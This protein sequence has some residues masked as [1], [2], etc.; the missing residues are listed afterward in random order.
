MNAHNPLWKSPSLNR[1][2]EIIESILDDFNFSVINTGLPTY[3]KSQAGTSILD[4]CL[5]SNSIA[6]KCTWTAINDTLGSDH[7]PTFTFIDEQIEP[8]NNCRI[9]W[10]CNKADHIS[11]LVKIILQMLLCRLM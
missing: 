6:L 10:L 11:L 5:V 7:C 4:L 8:E 1:R 3:Q 9:K 2:G